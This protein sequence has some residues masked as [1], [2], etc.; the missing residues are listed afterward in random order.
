MKPNNW[1]AL[2]AVQRRTMAL[3]MVKSMRGTYIISQALFIAKEELE[4]VTGPHREQ[5]NIEDM[6]MLI[7][8]LFSLYSPYVG[9]GPGDKEKH[10]PVVDE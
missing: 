2:S 3:G 9:K 10:P 8:G 5:S 7:E 1:E 6:E 4:K